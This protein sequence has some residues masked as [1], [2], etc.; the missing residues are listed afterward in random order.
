GRAVES[1]IGTN[2]TAATPTNPAGSGGSNNMVKTGVTAYDGGSA[3]G[4]SYV[5]SRSLDAD[6]DWTSSGD[7][8]T[9]TYTNDGI[10]R[11]GIGQDPQSPHTLTKYDN[12]GRVLAVGIYS[13]TSGQTV[14]TDPTATATNRLALSETLYDEKGRVYETVRHNIDVSDGSDDDT[15]T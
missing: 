1:W 14:T 2:D 13:S 15:L 7:R 10:G 4:N 8:R 9:T 6:G 11:P 3:G 12:R 5:T